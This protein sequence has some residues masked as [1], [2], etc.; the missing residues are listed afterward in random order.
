MPNPTFANQIRDLRLYPRDGSSKA[1]PKSTKIGLILGLGIPL[2]LV[3][4]SFFFYLALKHHYRRKQAR[5]W[6]NPNDVG[7]ITGSSPAR[8]GVVTESGGGRGGYGGHD[9]IG[10]GDVGRDSLR[11]DHTPQSYELTDQERD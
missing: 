8:N 1:I 3:I 10:A 11:K 4:L 9:G 5:G 6:T 2:F 7:V